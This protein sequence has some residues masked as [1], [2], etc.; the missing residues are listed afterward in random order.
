MELRPEALTMQEQ[1]EFISNNS[2]QSK[3]GGILTTTNRIDAETSQIE[4]LQE[5]KELANQIF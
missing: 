3:L 1:M 2:I 4:I 5:E